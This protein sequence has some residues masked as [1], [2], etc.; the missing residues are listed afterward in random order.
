MKLKKIFTAIKKI[1]APVLASIVYIFI[2]FVQSGISFITTP[3]FTRLL[4]VEEY[5]MTS[6]YSSWYNIAI[7]LLTLNL[8]CG[9]YNNGL[10]D[11]KDNRDKFTSSILSISIFNTIFIF[12]IYL[13]FCN[14]L[15]QL[16]GLPSI[17]IIFMFI[18]ILVT[19]AINLYITKEKFEYKWV[20]PLIITLFVSILNPICGLIGIK[21]FPLSKGIA[22]IIFFYLPSIVVYFGFLIYLLVKGKCFFSK[23]YWKYAL[24]FNIPLIPH[25]LANVLLAQSDRIMISKFFEDGISLVGIYG[26]AYTVATLL[27]YILN[28]INGAWIPFTYKKMQANKIC[29]IN[30][31]SNYIVIGA[32]VILNLLIIITPELINILAPNS[33]LD[34]IWYVPPIA[35]GLYFF[36]VASLFSNIE[37]YYKKNIYVMI[38]SVITAIINIVLNLIFIPIFGSIAAAYTTLIGYIFFAIFHYIFYRKIDKRPIYNIKSMSIVSF[39][40]VILITII[41][42]LYKY[43]IIRYS[44]VLI[45]I[46]YLILNR[47]KIISIVRK[48]GKNE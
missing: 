7:I 9:V 43:I 20:W 16:I 12:F 5:G 19:P 25:Y 29:D 11:F 34:A 15:N 41:M 1:P 40:N 28:G 46:V 13:L 42:C 35:L 10:L 22:K 36:F 39:I 2:V 6:L 48:M 37:F 38:G 3:I 21:L 8:Y 17:L 32:S 27:Q 44:L 31:Y 30:K 26:L 47:K 24:S 45:I 23:K 18:H 4:N 33:Y 14:K